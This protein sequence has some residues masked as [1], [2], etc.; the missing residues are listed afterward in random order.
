M[1]FDD[2]VPSSLLCPNFLTHLGKVFITIDSPY[3]GVSDQPLILDGCYY[4]VT[5]GL[6]TADDFNRLIPILKVGYLRQ[7]VR[8]VIITT[9]ARPIA[10]L[11][12]IVC[13][14]YSNLTDIYRSLV[15]SPSIDQ[16]LWLFFKQSGVH[17]CV[18]TSTKLL[19]TGTLDYDEFCSRLSE[20]KFDQLISFIVYQR[21]PIAILTEE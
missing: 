16:N 6:A 8:R 5:Q 7:D 15:S 21:G 19:L 18:K 12:I 4:A 9:W 14:T 11:L 20:A 13:P 17:R 10:D 3:L 1:R 2:Y